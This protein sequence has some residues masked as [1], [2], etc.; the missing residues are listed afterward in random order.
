MIFYY[1]IIVYVENFVFVNVVGVYCVIV[2]DDIWILV[3]WYFVLKY[4]WVGESYVDIGL[5][6]KKIMKGYK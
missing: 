6:F 4:W 2:I 3:L 5:W 1:L